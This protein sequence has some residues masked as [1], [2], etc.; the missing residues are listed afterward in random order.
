MVNIDDANALELMA[1]IEGDNWMQAHQGATD[2]FTFG[3]LYAGFQKLKAK[4]AAGAPNAAWAGLVEFGPTIYGRSSMNR[5]FV[6]TSGEIFFSRHHGT[7]D[8]VAKAVE[9][10]FSVR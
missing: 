1:K 6:D 3:H 4:R 2:P 7:A 5:Y 9:L 8:G 10:G